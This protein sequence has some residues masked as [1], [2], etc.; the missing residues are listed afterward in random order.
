MGVALT[1]GG[2][3][4]SFGIEVRRK[5]E[6]LYYKEATIKYPELPPS[7]TPPNCVACVPAYKDEMELYRDYCINSA[8][9]Y[10]L[11]H[12]Y[13]SARCNYCMKHKD[14]D[15]EEKY[16]LGEPEPRTILE[17]LEEIKKLRR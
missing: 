14:D 1:G 2:V 5:G 8:D 16:I 13:H 10:I 12:D 6:K 4:V 11:L 17:C 15:I 7:P 9:Y 3:D